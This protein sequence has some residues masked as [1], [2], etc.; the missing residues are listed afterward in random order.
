MF[1]VCPVRNE[2]QIE[3]CVYPLSGSPVDSLEVEAA[4]LL[5]RC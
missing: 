5:A 2:D 1:V 4:A 3:A